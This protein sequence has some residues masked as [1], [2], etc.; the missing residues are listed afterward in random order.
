MS[1]ELTHCV[2]VMPYGDTARSTLAQVMACCLTAPSHCLNQCW[3][4]ISEEMLKVFILD[5]SLKITTSR[6]LLHLRGVKW[7]KRYIFMYCARYDPHLFPQRPEDN[8]TLWRC[9]KRS[10]KV[11]CEAT[12]SQTGTTFKPNHLAHNHDC[13]PQRCIQRKVRAALSQVIDR[14]D[15]TDMSATEVVEETLA[16]FTARAPWMQSKK[17]ALIRMANRRRRSANKVMSY[18]NWCWWVSVYC[19]WTDHSKCDLLLTH[20]G[21]MKPYGDKDLSQHWLR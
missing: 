10:T 13:H 5:I 8:Y 20:W 6:L 17:S 7:V 9:T 3:L 14:M 16:K 11:G 12:V 18:Y 4:D 21:L 2:L 15:M 19:C 1:Q